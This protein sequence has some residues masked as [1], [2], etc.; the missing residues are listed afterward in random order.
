MTL[1]ICFLSI[2]GSSFA[3]C[4]HI[5]PVWTDVAV[6]QTA[7]ITTSHL[8]PGSHKKQRDKN[9]LDKSKGCIRLWP[10]A[11]LSVGQDQRLSLSLHRFHLS[12]TVRCISWGQEPSWCGSLSEQNYSSIRKQS[13][14]SKAERNWIKTA[15]MLWQENIHFN[16]SVRTML[17][18][19]IWH[20]TK[21]ALTELSVEQLLRVVNW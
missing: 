10:W 8:L 20:L 21:T 3:L 13:T 5:F 6:F 12:S 2:I 4:P 16:S 15:P 14:K 18:I 17:N 19:F 11:T 7:L 1:T 9:H